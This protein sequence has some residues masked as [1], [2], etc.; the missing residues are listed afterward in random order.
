MAEDSQGGRRRNAEKFI[1]Y[2]RLVDACAEPG[3]PVCRLVTHDSRQALTALLYEQVTDPDTRRRLKASWGFCNWHAWM[4]LGVA[5]SFSGAAIIY[6]DVVRTVT[7]HVRRL[8]DRSLRART[9]LLPRWLGRR[10]PQSAAQRVYKRRAICPVCATTADA[11]SRYLHTMLKFIT[12]PE[13]TLAYGTSAGLCVPHLVRVVELG[14]ATAEARELIDRTLAKWSSLRED[15][16]SFVRKHDHRNTEP[17]TE[18]ET[19]SYRRAFE[20]LAGATGVFG[21]DLHAEIEPVSRRRRI[22]ARGT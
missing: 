14:G 22:G 15:L 1:G 20:A 18:A 12:D 4:L 2:F 13:L 21:N 16:E 7:E 17:Y 6:E 10:S 5:D 3:C 11:E 9:P 19:A 8:A